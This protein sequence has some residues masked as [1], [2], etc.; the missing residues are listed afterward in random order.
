MK[1]L[2]IILLCTHLCILGF[3][4]T[5]QRNVI[6]EGKF[7]LD[8]LSLLQTLQHDTVIFEKTDT[9][10]QSK[11]KWGFFLFDRYS[12]FYARDW[13]RKISVKKDL[14]T[15][16][17]YDSA[18]DKL[19]SLGPYSSDPF[20]SPWIPIVLLFIFHGLMFLILR[21]KLFNIH[22]RGKYFTIRHERTELILTVLFIAVIMAAVG[23]GLKSY[24]FTLLP[25]WCL[26]LIFLPARTWYDP[27]T[28]M[29]KF[30]IPRKVR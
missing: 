22:Q 2:F 8:Q 16:F 27:L 18:S 21:I 6:I 11:W 17:S 19:R 29:E 3:S 26:V 24:F 23:F 5:S 13:Y 7:P 14:I 28:K 15:V 1:K 30:N 4:K 10:S 9:T 12:E 25:V 20:K